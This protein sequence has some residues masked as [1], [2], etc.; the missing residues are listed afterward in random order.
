[1]SE[2]QN[3][4]EKDGK[5]VR[6]DIFNSLGHSMTSSCFYELQTCRDKTKYK[7][8]TFVLSK[9]FSEVAMCLP[10]VTATASINNF[11]NAMKITT[12]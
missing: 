7:K 2:R 9:S 11:I 5:R 3:K 4:F 10:K 6:N 12:E 1:M 8:K